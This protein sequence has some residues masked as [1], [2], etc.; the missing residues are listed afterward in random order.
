[1]AVADVGISYDA[2]LLYA[3]KVIK[4]L[5]EELPGMYPGIFHDKPVF[6]G[7]QDLADSAVIL[8][9]SA[10]VDEPNIYSAR[11]ILLR[12]LKLSLDR[13]GIEI[14]YNQLD[15]RIVGGAKT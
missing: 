6:A 2:D 14:P 13:A 9:V 4:D 10:Q 7:V 8:R 12:E 3:E 11:R 1:M 5:L 15:V